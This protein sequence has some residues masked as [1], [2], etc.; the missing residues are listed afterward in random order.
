MM[1][2]WSTTKPAHGEQEQ[3]HRIGQ[4]RDAEH[5]GKLSAPQDQVDAR[6]R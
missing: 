4:E 3:V 2:G 1:G 6:R 5:D